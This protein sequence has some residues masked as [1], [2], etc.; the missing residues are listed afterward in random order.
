[1]WL[2]HNNLLLNAIPRLVAHP[3]KLILFPL[4]HNLDITEEILV[5]ES[6]THLEFEGLM[7]SPFAEAQ[8]W[9]PFK[10]RLIKSKKEAIFSLRVLV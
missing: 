3:A 6:I 4:I 1:M 2:N 7:H 10:S 5:L 9:I 8:L